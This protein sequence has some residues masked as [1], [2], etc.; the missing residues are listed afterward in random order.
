MPRVRLVQ[1]APTMA[2]TSTLLR[3]KVVFR[4]MAFLALLSCHHVHTT[5]DNGH[6][7]AF[8]IRAVR[9]GS[10]VFAHGL[11]A[12]ERLLALPATILHTLAGSALH[13]VQVGM[14]RSGC[15]SQ[16]RRPKL[17]RPG[18]RRPKLSI[19][20]PLCH[21]YAPAT[22]RQSRVGLC[23]TASAGQSFRRGTQAHRGGH[24]AGRC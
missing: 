2:H 4:S 3:G 1:D 15:I 9:C 5:W 11:G 12:L 24:L 16:P 6:L 18:K 17:L 8:A 21:Q 20:R 10:L 22:V 13:E 14:K 7:L 19:A 23:T